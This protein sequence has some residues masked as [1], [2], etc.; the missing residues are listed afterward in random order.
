MVYL[1]ATRE[2]DDRES[3]ISGTRGDSSRTP[4]IS[5][6]AL[7]NPR[8]F[9][10]ERRGSPDLQQSE[11]AQD[12]HP[13]L[14]VI[15]SDSEN[16]DMDEC[17]RQYSPSLIPGD[18]HQGAHQYTSSPTTAVSL[19]MP[20]QVTDTVEDV[21]SLATRHCC[22]FKSN[23]I[24]ESPDEAPSLPRPRRNR[25]VKA[26]FPTKEQET[27]L[28]PAELSACFSERTNLM[29]AGLDLNTTRPYFNVQA[30]ADLV[31]G[32]SIACPS[33]YSRLSLS[34]SEKVSLN[35][36]VAHVDFS[37]EEVE[38]VNSIIRS[39]FH[40]MS[41]KS[42]DE[43][44]SA[45]ILM[46]GKDSRI[47]QILKACS[48]RKNTDIG[49]IGA[50][51]VARRT[52]SALRSF[53]QDA[54]AGQLS[55]TAAVV[56]VEPSS[57]FPPAKERY[58]NINASLFQRS[59]YGKHPGTRFRT[60]YSFEATLTNLMEDTLSRRAEWTDCA[61]DVATIAWT[62][63]GGFV[64]GATAHLDSH[65]M[66]YNK[67]GNLVVGS[68]F[69]KDVT[70]IP[71]HRISRPL[72]QKGD[73]ALPSMR[74]TQDPW[75]YCSVTS[76]GYSEEY[77][78]CFTGGF[79][80]TVKIWELA[81]NGS[82]M[83]LKGTWEH[84]GHVNFVMTSLHHGLIATAS[85]VGQ[86]AIRVYELNERDVSNSSYD[87]YSGE[88]AE[89]LAMARRQDSEVR[90]AYHP[91]TMA[92]GKSPSVAHLLLVGYSPRSYDCEDTDI[93]EDKAKTG[94]LCLW[95]MENGERIPITTARTQNVFEVVWHPALPIFVAAT[96]PLG[97]FA[98]GVRTQ[99]RLFGQSSTGTFTLMKTLD[100]MALDINEITVM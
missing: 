78:R 22:V 52:K 29:L 42:A 64:C 17:F 87:T 95:S 25:F 6:R 84:D 69:R 45:Q 31:R 28:L 50:R 54:A 73:N 23:P 85:D 92:W 43:R 4:L 38:Y 80:G 77:N 46:Y 96:S 1:F 2:L 3:M 79:D 55:K 98:D 60:A 41:P 32:L 30:R 81:E 56:R 33:K 37:T 86:D 71:G 40:E 5:L 53:L 26:A 62:P 44:T 59:I 20:K 72:V 58:P 82:S 93:P 34:V 7:S 18:V 65:N 10:S 68:A 27:H 14:L 66:Q 57:S 21:C 76:I 16:Q 91:A 90:W 48:S 11:Y 47:P 61:G 15:L 97:E 83:D 99:L 49:S 70:S 88:K 63:N 8:A 75:L 35:R 36:A 24:L 39:V 94:E 100:C 67:P 13:E 12:A 89:E 74:Q 9:S 51:L 19:E